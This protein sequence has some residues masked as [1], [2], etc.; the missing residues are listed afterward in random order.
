MKAA[1]YE[2]GRKYAQKMVRAI[3]AA[4]GEGA[5]LVVTDCSLSALRIRKENQTRV[6][7]PVEAMREAYGI[8]E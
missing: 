8:P 6:L 1:H 7:H 3:D 4:R 5:A 2:Q